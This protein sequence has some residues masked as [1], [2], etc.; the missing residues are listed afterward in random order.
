MQ[1][2]DF[3]KIILTGS[4]VSNGVVSDGLAFAIDGG[5]ITQAGEWDAIGKNGAKVIDLRRFT[6]LPGLVD[7]HMH[8]GNG[9]DT[10]DGTYASVNAMSLYKLNEGVTSFCPSTVTASGEKTRAAAR[11]VGEAVAKGTEGA[12]VMG[13]FLEGPY[14]NPKN[15]GAHPAEFIRPMDITEMKTLTGEAGK[16]V[17][18]IAIAPELP[19][20]V[21]AIRALSE[22]GVNI[23]LGH[24]SASL[25]EAA[26]AVDAGANIAIHT[27]NAMSALNHREPGMV[28]AAMSLDGL[29]AEIIC[30]LVHV[31]PAAVKILVKAR[32][33]DNTVL[34]T[35]C[36]S[37]GGLR[38]G[39]YVLGELPVYVKGGVC[40]LADGTL[41]GSTAKLIDCVKNACETVGIPLADAVTMATSAPARALGAFNRIGSLDAGKQ[42]DIIAIDEGF[43]VRYVMVDGVEKINGI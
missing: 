32:G 4:S 11:S 25:E 43:N 34:I 17:I 30:D 35:D 24:S 27:Y 19:G 16:G 6:V 42:A 12:K 22:A 5:K 3:M 14:I 9:F 20:A 8:G 36:M 10:M 1:R 31:H 18:S 15:K 28:G 7:I 37:A 26:A 39:E 41:A 13:I 33:A 38:D 21:E 29:Y 2:G 40:R 23:R